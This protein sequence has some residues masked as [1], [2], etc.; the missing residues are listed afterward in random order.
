MIGIR[1]R[2]RVRRR[3]VWDHP[4]FWIV[5]GSL[6]CGL[7]E[8]VGPPLPWWIYV[9]LVALWAGLVVTDQI[10]VCTT[11][12]GFWNFVGVA[13]WHRDTPP[14]S[15]DAER[16]LRTMITTYNNHFG[17]DYLVEWDSEERS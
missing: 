14:D 1:N 10:L 13:G 15:W 2:V 12:R 3:N 11:L 17:D 6:S 9:L 4:V 8:A 7:A 5:V 16:F